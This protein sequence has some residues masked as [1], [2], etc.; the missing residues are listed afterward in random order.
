MLFPIVAKGLTL[1][2]SPVVPMVEVKVIVLG[3]LLGEMG[4]TYYWHLYSYSAGGH[5]G[6]KWPLTEYAKKYMKFTY[7]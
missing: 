2:K 3:P 4:D 7:Y 6:S 5:K 1:A